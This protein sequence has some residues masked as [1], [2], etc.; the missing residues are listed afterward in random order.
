GVENEQEFLAKIN[1]NTI[2]EAELGE[3]SYLFDELPQ[4]GPGDRFKGP[5]Y[6]IPLELCSYF[7]HFRRRENEGVHPQFDCDK[8]KLV[9][10]VRFVELCRKYGWEGEYPN[11][12]RGRGRLHRGPVRLLALSQWDPEDEAELRSLLDVADV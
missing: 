1:E 10:K 8:L 7:T 4:L 6:E 5:S 12:N 11:P 3:L 2:T 9:Q